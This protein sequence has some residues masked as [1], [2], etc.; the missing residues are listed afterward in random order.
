MAKF[1]L[2]GKRLDYSFS[3]TFFTDFFQKNG[4]NHTYENIEIP[5]INHVADLFSN[6]EFQGFN[7]TIPYK[8][9]I[10]P[11]LTKLSPE[12]AKIGAVNTV[13][14]VN[15]EWIGYNTDAFGFKQSIKPF[16]D[17]RHEKALILGT[18]GASKAI[19]FVLKEIGLDVLF[20]SRNPKGKNEFSYSD[21]NEFMLKAYKMV[22]N[23]TPVGTFPNVN[24]KPDFPTQLLT[25]DHFVVDLIYNPEKTRLLTEAAQQGA[26]I[27]NGYSMLQEQALKAWDIWKSQ[28]N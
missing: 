26:M 1:G 9:E 24:E 10:I 22:V 8:E 5:M 18:G 4:L 6:S 16:L 3:K 7:V 11:Y 15:G 19:E 21:I 2:I 14:K 12:A 20:I 17:S 25:P 28:L 13:A 27:L 23:C